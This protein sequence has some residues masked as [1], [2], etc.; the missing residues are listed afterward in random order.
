M[1]HFPGTNLSDCARKITSISILTFLH[2]FLNIILLFFISF[3]LSFLILIFYHRH[4]FLQFLTYEA[5]VM[6]YAAIVMNT[7]KCFQILYANII[8]IC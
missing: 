6:T 7:C 1:L 4:C 3:L 8:L 2:T 5:I